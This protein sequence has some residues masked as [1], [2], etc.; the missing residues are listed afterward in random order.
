MLAAILLLATALR[1]YQLGQQLWLD[2]IIMHVRY[3]NAGLDKILTTFDFN[4]HVLYTILAKFS[5]FLMGDSPSALRLP[6]A[7][8]GIGSIGALFILASSALGIREALLSSG[9]LTLSYHHIWFSQN[10]RGYTGLLFWTLISSYFLL[11]AFQDPRRRFWIAYAFSAALG[12]YISDLILVVVAGHFVIYLARVIR[13]PTRP[14]SDRFAGVFFGFG[15]A[16]AIAFTLSALLLPQKL[17]AFGIIAPIRDPLAIFSTA[18][19]TGRLATDWFRPRWSASEAIRILQQGMGS[20]VILGGIVVFGFGCFRLARENKE[21]LGLFFIPV[22]ILGAAHYSLSGFVVFP[23][24][25]FW[26]AGFAIL[27]ATSGILFIADSAS[28]LFTARESKVAG[29][30][31]GLLAILVSAATVPAAYAPKQD[32]EGALHF[33]EENRSSG[34]AVILASH[35]T[36]IPYRLYYKVDWANPKTAEELRVIRANASTTWLVYTLPLQLSP[37]W[38]AIIRESSTEEARFR[39]TLGGGDIVVCR[40]H[41]AED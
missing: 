21:I 25:F 17:A 19:D 33:I 29:N 9:L 16:G 32:Y 1:F 28:R 11:R 2:E 12:T 13:G 23:R 34:D 3:M 14:W 37:G 31:A 5:V 15:L 39:G 38:L 4:N 41:K 30:V 40:F 36:V 26:A 27:I 6:A 7:L 8:F 20:V 22:G 18:Y 24:F 10:A 35:T